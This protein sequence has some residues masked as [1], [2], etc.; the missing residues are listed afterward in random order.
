M[1]GKHLIIKYTF[2]IL[3]FINILLQIVGVT[4]CQNLSLTNLKSTANERTNKIEQFIESRR[5]NAVEEL[6]LA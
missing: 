2:K 3:A 5:T 6:R 4:L 1:G